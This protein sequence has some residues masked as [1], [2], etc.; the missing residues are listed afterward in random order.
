MSKQPLCSHRVSHYPACRRFSEESSERLQNTNRS[1]YLQN[2]S[3]AR[4]TRADKE[5]LRNWA[6]RMKRKSFREPLPLPCLPILHRPAGR[7]P[8]T[9][10]GSP[11]K[12]L[13][14]AVQRLSGYHL[15]N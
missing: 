12:R 4:V 2:C 11:I 3:G 7:L 6:D 8:I 1:N 5:V 10:D 15:G 13:L 9:R 14:A